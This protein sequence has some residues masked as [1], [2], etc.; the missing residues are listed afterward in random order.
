MNVT[1]NG[2]VK[3]TAKQGTITVTEEAVTIPWTARRVLGTY[4]RSVSLRGF[5]RVLTRQDVREVSVGGQDRQYLT[6]KRAAGVVLTGGAALLAPSRVRGSLVITT[7]AGDVFEFVLERA[8]AK[9]SEAIAA[10][11]SSRG[12]VVR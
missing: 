9:H 12:Y 10:A 11:F 1:R 4:E 7:T 2:S 6:G 8:E 3:V 5:A